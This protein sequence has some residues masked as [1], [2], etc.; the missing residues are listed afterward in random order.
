MTFPTDL[1][2]TPF[3][4]T[5]PLT[6][7]R[8]SL[9]PSGMVDFFKKGTESPV[10]QKGTSSRQTISSGLPMTASTPSLPP[11]NFTTS[12]PS[13]PT[14]STPFLPPPRQSVAPPAS[15]PVAPPASDPVAPPA[16]PPSSDLPAHHRDPG[17][18]IEDPTGRE[19]VE[20]ALRE[21]REQE[22][23]ESAASDAAKKKLSTGA[24]VGLTI[25]GVAILGGLAY[26]V[27]R[28][29]DNT[30]RAVANLL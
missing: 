13:A 17:R 5:T 28:R 30:V 10:L 25:G 29:S 14:G 23:L 2:T 27:K 3:E 24:I 21:A 11:V 8:G 9:T 7:G 1:S 4:P 20:R 26:L 15:D 6:K 16:A 19:G 22:E 18:I 12:V